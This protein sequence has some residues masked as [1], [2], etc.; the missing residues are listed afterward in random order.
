MLRQVIEGRLQ[1]LGEETQR[2]LAVAA[3]IGQEVPFGLWQSVS[4]TSDDRLAE[5]I[6]RALEAH[7]VEEVP[8]GERLRF[9]HALV[10]ETLYRQLLPPFRRTWHRRVGEALEERTFSGRTS[11]S[12][13]ACPTRAGPG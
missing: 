13:G 10:R 7:L 2:Q 6:R 3:V 8:G 1:R 11:V 5:V 9:V 12:L 4:G